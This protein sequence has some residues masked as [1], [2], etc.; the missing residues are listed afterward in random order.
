MFQC[1]DPSIS[2]LQSK[3]YLVVLLPKAGVRPS[4]I[5]EFEG[6]QLNLLG[7]LTKFLIAGSVPAPSISPDSPMPKISGQQTS[8]LRIGIGLSILGNILGAMGASGLDLSGTYKNAKSLRFEFRDVFG[9]SID[10]VSLDQYVGAADVNPTSVYVS[11]L[12]VSSGLAIIT[13][14]IKSHKIVVEALDAKGQALSVPIPGVHGVGG[15][16][17]VSC[18]S[19]ASSQLTY[20]GKIPLVFGIMARKL[21]LDRG[22]YT[23]KP[24][25]PPVALKGPKSILNDGTHLLTADSPIV[26]LRNE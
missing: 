10:V 24:I 2:Y 8:N 11:D 26:Q 6:K 7:E 13:D 21:F 9:N 3:G 14:I 17:E 20:K 12:L 19:S 15:D 4:Q 25:A 5:C 1:I 16:V 18:E 22:K 23:L